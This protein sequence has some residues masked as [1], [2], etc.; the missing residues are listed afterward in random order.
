[1]LMKLL[2]TVI[3][4]EAKNILLRHIYQRAEE[5]VRLKTLTYFGAVCT[6][7]CTY[8]HPPITTQESNSCNWPFSLQLKPKRAASD[9]LLPEHACKVPRVS[10][11]HFSWTKCSMLAAFQRYIL[12]CCKLEFGLFDVV[13][14]IVSYRLG[15]CKFEVW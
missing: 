2:L 1:M 8:L 4:S 13:N 5:K 9:N 6:C 7:L 10:T 14:Y 11:W 3:S 12:L 15:A